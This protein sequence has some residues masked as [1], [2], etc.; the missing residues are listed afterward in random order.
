MV[1][2]LALGAMQLPKLFNTGQKMVRKRV[3]KMNKE[4][5]KKEKF[6]KEKFQLTLEQELSALQEEQ[7]MT[8]AVMVV[9][10]IML[11]V[12]LAVT[13][14][15]IVLMVKVFFDILKNCRDPTEKLIHLILFWTLPGY[16]L[17][18]IFLRMGGVVCK[19]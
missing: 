14:G 15:Y 3:K 2:T 11:L 9:F 6:K 1:L 16:E 12:I 4:K 17:M 18:Y 5:F 10:V 13:I 7:E 8:A 19:K